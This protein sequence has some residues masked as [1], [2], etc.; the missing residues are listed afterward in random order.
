MQERGLV[1]TIHCPTIRDIHREYAV[2]N[3]GGRT[4]TSSRGRRDENQVWSRRPCELR[5]V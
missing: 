1:V 3:R 2:S 5:L 4:S